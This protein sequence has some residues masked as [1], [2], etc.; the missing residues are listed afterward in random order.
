MKFEIHQ[1]CE[2]LRPYVKHFI[3]SEN[4]EMLKYNVIPGTSLV[5]GFQ[6]SG[7]LSYLDNDLEIPLATAGVTG[8]MDTCRTFKNQLL[9]GT[10]LVVFQETG[11]THFFTNPVNELFRESIAL[12][13]IFNN[14]E[15]RKAE[16]LLS[17][18]TN[19]A[20]RIKVIELL[21]LNHLHNIPA[22]LLVNKAIQY[23]Y[24]SKGTIRISELAYKLNTR[25]KISPG[26]WSFS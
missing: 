25:K 13:H 10:V 9:T 2:Q 17:T 6:Y 21:L 24:H 5:M 11:A 19:D 1:P 12:E 15:L 4:D 20:S 3:I 23:I 26:C 16:E 8:L 22:D 18:A 14:A 7:Q